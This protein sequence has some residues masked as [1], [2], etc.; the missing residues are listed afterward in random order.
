MPRVGNSEAHQPERLRRFKN[1]FVWMDGFPLYCPLWH[2]GV[3][4]PGDVAM[5][6][7][8]LVVM[9]WLKWTW[10]LCYG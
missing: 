1:M 5:A 8:D 2:W 4:G 10:W 3:S 7:V 6:E 9:L